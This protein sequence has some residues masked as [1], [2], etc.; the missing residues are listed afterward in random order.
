MRVERGVGRRLLDKVGTGKECSVLVRV[1]E[2]GCSGS[3]RLSTR[4]PL[5]QE[6]C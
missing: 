5:S 2:G 1:Q 4:A 3:G 6:L